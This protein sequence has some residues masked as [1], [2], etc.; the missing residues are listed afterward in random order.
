METQTTNTATAKKYVAKKNV[1]GNATAKLELAKLAVGQTISYDNVILSECDTKL[2]GAVLMAVFI[3]NDE[4][5]FKTWV[6]KAMKSFLEK[7]PKATS[8]TLKSIIEDGD[9]SYYIYE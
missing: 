2:N 1:K 9:L 3:L 6:N 7:N 8:I 5:V 4:I